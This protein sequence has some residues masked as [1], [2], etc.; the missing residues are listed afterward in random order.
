[1][2]FTIKMAIVVIIPISFMITGSIV[3]QV[4]MRN[5]LETLAKVE[6]QVPIGQA[7]SN[8]ETNH[9]TKLVWL[10][11]GFMAAEINDEQVLMQAIKGFKNLHSYNNLLFNDAEY[12]L[13]IMELDEESLTDDD[14][15]ELLKNVQDIRLIYDEFNKSG[16]DLFTVLQAEDIGD[17][18]SKLRN[19]ETEANKLANKLEQLRTVLSKRSMDA[20]TRAKMDGSEALIITI[21]IAGILA[22]CV[23]LIVALVARSIRSQLGADP[24]VLEETTLALANGELQLDRNTE[25]GGVYAS[26][27]DTMHKLGQ[28]IS[29]IH[30][31]AAKVLNST[32]EVIKGNTSL[33][34]RMQEQTSSLE[35]VAS[36][37]EEMAS[38]V[39]QTS[40][41][42]NQVNTLAKASREKAEQGS[43]VINQTVLAMDDI[44]SSSRQ[45]EEIIQVVDDLA[46]QTNLL[47][48]NAAVEAA[49]AGEQG[50]GFAV[51][52]S[53]V[54]NLAGRSKDAAQQIKNLIEDSVAKVDDGSRLVDESN[55][56]L[57]DIVQSVKQVSEHVAEIATASRE[58][59]EG[60]ELINSAL[61]Q[62]DG[63]TQQNATV[64]E[65]AATASESMGDEAK[66]LSSLVDYFRLYRKKDGQS[67]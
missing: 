5:M 9:I 54:R 35:E 1:M 27:Q 67:E 11:R 49:R 50:K 55:E 58:Q 38:S 57:K 12:R 45:I 26:I 48:L 63:M 32:E 21:V 33:S 39:N 29:S 6:K 24:T 61:S 4:Y 64:V 42:A 44:R 22:C 31:G 47:A 30:E 53:E 8:I 60:I 34:Q 13:S 51:V 10:E 56:F 15:G 66:E 23:F 2:S 41:N 14:I 46:F 37:I 16:T 25:A 43:K 19:I 40:E 36:N 62:I 7:I 3:D 52:A 28:V 20:A 65:Q 59:S 17:A 18:E